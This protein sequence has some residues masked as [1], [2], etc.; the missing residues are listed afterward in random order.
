[1]QLKEKQMIFEAGEQ[2][3][4]VYRALYAGSG[5]RHFVGKVQNA[6]GAVCRLEGFAFVY[7][8]KTALFDKK[9]EKRV[10]VIDLAES[11]YIVNMIDGHVALENV[12]YS[13]EIGVGLI[14]TDGAGFTLNISEFSQKN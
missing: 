8:K 1:L 6:E 12:E 2:V 9:P 7:D 10:T 3:H 13:Y 4:V 14:A 11:G 5:R